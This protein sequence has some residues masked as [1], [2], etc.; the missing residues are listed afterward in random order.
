MNLR[1]FL[2]DFRAEND[3]SRK[4]S[5]TPLVFRRALHGK[6]FRKYDSSSPDPKELPRFLL[7]GLS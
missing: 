4:T 3:F 6:F 7:I 2:E 5:P 1:F